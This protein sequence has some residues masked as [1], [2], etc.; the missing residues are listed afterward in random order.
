MKFSKNEVLVLRT[1]NSDMTSYNK[2]LW[3]KSG[4]VEALDWEAAKR[5]DNGLHGF[6]WGEGN[7]I[8]ASW[9]FWNSNRWRTWES[10]CWGFWSSKFWG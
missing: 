1:C 8:L 2:F 5:C 6:L 4:F 3:P 7:G 10:N 9:G